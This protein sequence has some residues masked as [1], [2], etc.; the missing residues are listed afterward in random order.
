M[1]IHIGKGTLDTTISRRGFVKGAA[2]LTF[3][4]TLGGSMLGRMADAVAQ[5][6][7]A[8]KLNAW[9]TIGADNMITILC[10]SS[11]MGQ[12]VLTALPLILAEELD[13]D[14]SKVKCE[15][16]PG[17]PK[18]YGGVHKMFPG[19]Q[20]TLASVSVPSY[21]VPLRTA[22]AQARKV[23][24]DS[25]AKQWNVPVEE[26]T[27]EPSVVVHAKSNRRISYGDVAKFA[28]VPAEPPKITEADLKKPAQF[29]LIGRKDI[30]RVDVPSKVNGTAKFGIDVQVPG[31]V[32]ASVLESPMDGAKAEV[33][34][35][36]DV[37]KI[38]GVTR[39]IPL[40]FGVAVIG[41]TVEAT[42]SGRNALKVKWDTSQ[43]KAAPFE[44]REGEGGVRPQGQGS[45]HRGE[46]VVQGRRCGQ[47]D[48]RRGQG[49]GG[50]LL[51]GA[52][53]SRPDGADE[54]RRQRGGG[55]PVGGNLGRHAGAAA[56]RQRGRGR[57]QDHARQD[58]DPSAIA[59]RRLR[60]AHLA[61]RSG[62]G[63]GDLQ[64]R[65]EAGQA[66]PHARGRRRGRAAA[67]DDLSRAQG[68]ARR[69]EQSGRL[70][71]S[72]GG[73]ERRRRCRS[74]ALRGDRRQG[75]HRL[76]GSR[77]GVLHDPEHQ[78]RRRPRDPRHARSRMARHRCGLQQ[79][80]ERVLRG[81]DRGRPRRRP[82][83][84]PARAH[85][86]P[87]ARQCGG[88]GGGRDVGVEQEARRP[89]PGLRVLR[90]PRLVLG[91]G[92]RGVGRPQHRQDQGPQLLDRGR[93]R[94]D[95][96]ARQRRCPARKRRRL[97]AERRSVGGADRQGRRR[98]AVQLQRLPGAADERSSGNPYPD[99]RHAAI[100]RPAWASW[101]CPASRPASPTPSSSSPAS[102]SATCRCRR[103]G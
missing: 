92:G 14:W 74:A 87:S 86:R 97:R 11:E 12:G 31:M 69:Q 103:I 7:T 60:P 15:F 3:A 38:K 21:Y 17:N 63:G 47:G 20:V 36:P 85:E 77:A 62:A 53:L 75:R 67:A 51:V 58:Q 29:R 40:P 71:P 68:R 64:H 41:D 46:G 98:P 5:P 50:D 48:R 16:A 26:L 22:G 37:T 49:A 43:A 90:L 32:Y 89:R 93:C 52:H 65:Q 88:Q 99:H 6:Q 39:V 59:G 23:L 78:G 94:P 13:A 91:R 96:P 45:G 27:T 9:V 102:G 76:A 80:R 25:V 83:R 61:G 55:R 82:A 72:P 57:A 100:R 33:L 73:R 42:R 101:A 81:R 34:N 24:L 10:P 70:A 95:H 84:D 30:G 35:M 79:V 18:L 1:T 4:F 2:G 28:T 19:A 44:L 54:R 56:R 8:A 66:D